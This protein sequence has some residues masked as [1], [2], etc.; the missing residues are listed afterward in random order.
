MGNIDYDI[1]YLE[2]AFV[3]EKKLG[4]LEFIDE[5]Y[6]CVGVPAVYSEKVI[7]SGAGPGLEVI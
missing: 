2:K 3:S 5:K 7:V 1:I 4:Q 6:D